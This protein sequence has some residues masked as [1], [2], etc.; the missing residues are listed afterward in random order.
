MKKIVTGL[1]LILAMIGTST[2]TF[3]LPALKDVEFLVNHGD[4]MSPKL[5]LG[6]QIVSSKVQLLKCTYDFSKLGGTVGTKTLKAVDGAD[7]L[8]PSKAIVI[9][10]LIDV[11]TNPVGATATIAV[12]SGQA[13][14]DIKAATA[15]ASFTGLLD[16]IPVSTAATSIK[17]TADRKPSMTIA[18][19]A[20]TAGKFNVFFEFVLSD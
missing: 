6:T 8:I 10:V 20:L 18:T 17:M 11:I 13:T 12:G 16:G 1:F 7:C 5:M 14:N 9:D 4:V 3:A 15:V 19:A 2:Q